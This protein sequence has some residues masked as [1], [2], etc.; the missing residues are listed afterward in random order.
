MI[1]LK[2]VQG[3][4][5]ISLGEGQEWL[6][7]ISSGY[8][9]LGKVSAHSSPVLHRATQ[10]RFQEGG[11]AEGPAASRELSARSLFLIAPEETNEVPRRRG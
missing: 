4:E 7:T 1:L 5:V 3:I 8:Q 2:K 9:G 10:L 11:V 6:G